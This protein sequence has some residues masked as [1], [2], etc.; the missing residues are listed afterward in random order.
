MAITRRPRARSRDL[1]H[2]SSRS[3]LVSAEGRWLLICCVAIAALLPWGQSARATDV[4]E[5]FRAGDLES[6]ETATEATTDD[7]AD[8]VEVAVVLAPVDPTADTAAEPEELA[9]DPLSITVEQLSLPTDLEEMIEFLSANYERPGAQLAIEEALATALTYNHDLNSKRLAAAAACQGVEV[10]W[11]DL[12]P[13]LSLQAKGYL[14][15]SNANTDPIE[16]GGPDEE[17][18]V[19]DIAG[20]QDEVQRQ[21]ALSL[22]QRIYDFGITHDLIDIAE[23]QHA[24]QKYT[25]D[26]A[27][28]QLVSDVISAYFTFN[29]ALG[30]IKIHDD[31]FE[32]AEELLRQAEIQFRVGVV[33]RLDVIRAE[34]RVEEAR[35]NYIDAQAQLGDAA[36]YFFSLLGVE[37]SRYVPSVVGIA[38][39]E[40]GPPPPDVNA[41]VDCALQYRPE[42]E[43]QYATLS[44]TEAAKSLTRNRPILEAYA[45]AMYQ[46][47]TG[48]F[49]GTDNYEYGV[50][51]QWNLYTGGRD[52]AQ[53]K[54]EELN[55]MSISEGIIHLEAQLELDATT[56]WN[57]V[58]AARG[59]ADSARVGLDLAAEAHRAAAVGY[60]A[61]VTPYIDYLDALDKN[62]A[63]AN[64]YLIALAEVKIAQANLARAMGFPY[65]FPG[66]GRTDSPGDVDIY[67]TLGLTPPEVVL[68][69]PT[70]GAGG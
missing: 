28:Q 48:A 43:L 12:R 2:P 15:E 31:E 5:V 3:A 22:T 68:T 6:G 67:T 65:G 62:V 66:D 39:I 11:A 34:A 51:L 23:A 7:E 38:L 16:F 53:L 54:Q 36:A 14:T 18:T 69:E 26:M 41:A 20:P 49:T 40:V 19:I 8:A 1:E 21:L 33:P 60:S 32:L 55:L 61:G 64:G 45:N 17:P 10:Q 52:R 35:S 27:E 9:W 46:E 37:D 59:S 56:A 30:L 44:A 57:R 42:I 29:L 58:V 70:D 50:H 4:V 13:Q 63:A 24:I 47:P 25:V